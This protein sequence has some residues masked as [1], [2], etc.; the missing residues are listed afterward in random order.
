MI[1]NTILS[2]G[3]D[4]SKIERTYISLD[5]KTTVKNTRKF[6]IGRVCGNCVATA[7]L[8]ISIYL[9]EHQYK[10]STEKD[11]LITKVCSIARIRGLTTR[12]IQN[13]LKALLKFG[14]I[15][16]YQRLGADGIILSFKNDLIYLFNTKIIPPLVPVLLEQVKNNNSNVNFVHK[17]IEGQVCS[18][19]VGKQEVVIHKAEC[20]AFLEDFWKR[21]RQK[22]YPKLFISKDDEQRI[23][24]MIWNNV[25]NK[26]RL[27]EIFPSWSIFQ[28]SLYK[29]ILILEKYILRN[30]TDRFILPPLIYFN[31]GFNNCGFNNTYQ[32]YLK[33]EL[34]KFKS[35]S[36]KKSERPQ[37]TFDLLRSRL[38]KYKIWQLENEF[39][40]I[41]SQPSI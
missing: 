32:W 15:Y 40:K 29:R 7:E 37:E 14:F 24:N 21:F 39:Q 20:L 27:P 5:Y 22:F 23:K 10:S 3:D 34:L 35:K 36:V 17:N 30:P 41:F 2:N 38:D 13:H 19:F 4:I 11:N 12:T 8:L 26:F 33:S 16:D 18:G 1:G 31:S 25:F 9:K 6:L 28:I